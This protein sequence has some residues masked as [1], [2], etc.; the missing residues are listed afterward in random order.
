M[1]YIGRF[2]MLL[3][4]LAF[5]GRWAFAKLAE[6]SPEAAQDVKKKIGDKVLGLLN[7]ALK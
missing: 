7:R 6:S 2:F 4:V 3:V 5:A 1:E